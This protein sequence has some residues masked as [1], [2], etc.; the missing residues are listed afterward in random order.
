MT[1]ARQARW[2]ILLAALAPS[3]CKTAR[4]DPEIAVRVRDAE[5]KAP[6]AGATL[7]LTDLRDPFTTKN[8]TA[9]TAA[10]GSAHVRIQPQ[11]DDGLM[12]VTAA[13]YLT[14]AIEVH[15]TKVAQA[16]PAAKPKPQSQSME[17]ELFAGPRPTV[18]L[19]IPSAFRGL[20]KAEFKIGPDLP[21]GTPSP[22]AFRI[23]V[24]ADGTATVAGP[25]VLHCVTPLSF[26]AIAPDGKPLPKEGLPTD[27]FLRWVKT[28]DT[29]DY[30]VYGTQMDCNEARKK[31]NQDEG[32]HGGS[33]D[34]GKGKGG[35]GGGRRGGGSGAS[36]PGGISQ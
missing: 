10:D 34:S 2:L 22:R 33:G 3:G 1:T 27:I 16:D 15:D 35:R 28:T 31:L 17:I 21:P 36:V 29:T 19:V 20:I 24:A 9:T 13:G 6:I 11:A 7:R 18:E 4:P 30:F 12:E 23:D 8:L 26:S 32:S 5:T 14:E 25:P